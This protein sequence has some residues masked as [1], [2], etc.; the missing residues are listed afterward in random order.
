MTDTFGLPTKFI[1]NL[2]ALILFFLP[3]LK[4]TCVEKVK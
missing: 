4:S 1:T 3:K 2:A